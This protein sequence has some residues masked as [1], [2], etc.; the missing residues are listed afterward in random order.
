MAVRLFVC[1]SCLVVTC[2]I[3]VCARR[4]LFVWLSCDCVTVFYDVYAIV[5]H[6]LCRVHAF[7][8]R[9]AY[10]RCAVVVRCCVWVLR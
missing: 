9:F 8:L 6:V 2:L 5:V 7:V 3:F 10:D 4:A 1:V